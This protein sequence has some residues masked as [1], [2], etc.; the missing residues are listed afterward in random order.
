MPINLNRFVSTMNARPPAKSSDFEVRIFCPLIGSSEDLTFRAE[1]INIP[2]RNIATTENLDVGP[3]RKI[4]YTVMY[5]EV[6]ITF[7]LSV[8][9]YVKE[10]FD[11]WVDE[12]IGPHRVQENPGGNRFN[13]GYYDDYKGTIEIQNFTRTGQPSYKT[14]LIEA[15]PLSIAGVQLDWGS[16]DYSK[17]QV[18]FAYRYYIQDSTNRNTGGVQTGFGTVDRSGTPIVT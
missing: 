8:R 5:P 14:K 12:I 7:I 4:G 16:E 15:W 13:A 3:Q 9:Y 2:G 10:Y 11:R 17:L 1:N 18:T 6:T